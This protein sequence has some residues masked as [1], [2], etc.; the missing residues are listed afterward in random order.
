MFAQHQV[1][2]LMVSTVRYGIKESVNFGKEF[3]TFCAQVFSLLMEKKLAIDIKI[4]FVPHDNNGADKSKDDTQLSQIFSSHFDK[5]KIFKQY[6]LPK[7]CAT[8]SKHLIQRS[9]AFMSFTSNKNYGKKTAYDFRV[10]SVECH[11]K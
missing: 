8:A 6:K 3:D 5:D 10:S 11:S 7:L 9:A 2:F 1:A 4:T